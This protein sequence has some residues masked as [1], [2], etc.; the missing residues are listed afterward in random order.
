MTTGIGV[1]WARLESEIETAHRDMNK[2]ALALAEEYL[3]SGPTKVKLET[4]QNYSN[5]RSAFEV[6]AARNIERQQLLM[7]EYEEGRFA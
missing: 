6:V 5:A 4:V 2:A 7:E 1:E 3:F